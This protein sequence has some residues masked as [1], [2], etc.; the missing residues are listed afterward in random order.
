MGHRISIHRFSL[1]SIHDGTKDS[2]G[3][4][5]Q[6]SRDRHRPTTGIGLPRSGS[7]RAR[8][9]RRRPTGR[10]TRYP[11]SLLGAGTGTGPGRFT[12]GL[13]TA[14]FPLGLGRRR[15]GRM[16]AGRPFGGS[17]GFSVSWSLASGGSYRCMG[18]GCV[19]A[20]VSVRVRT[21]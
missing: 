9:R 18:G 12:G 6:A 10:S 4:R 20:I 14:A 13:F 2:G 7:T 21:E 19:V 15:G 8:V 5:P 3:H 17:G 11:T 1:Q 16:A